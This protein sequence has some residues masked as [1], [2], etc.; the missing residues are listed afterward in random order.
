M[1]M[2]VYKIYIYI[3]KYQADIIYIYTLNF[4][5]YIMIYIMCMYVCIT[6]LHEGRSFAFAGKN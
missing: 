4:I 3:I 5:Y 1:C 6:H 2:Y